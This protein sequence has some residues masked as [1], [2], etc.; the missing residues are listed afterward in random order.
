MQYEPV[1]PLL[2]IYSKKTKTLILK[3]MHP[4]DYCRISYYNQD[5]E[6]TSVS[7]HSDEWM[8]MWSLYK[9]ILLSHTKNGILPFVTTWIDIEIIMLSETIQTEED[10]QRTISF[11]CRI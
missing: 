2:G 1:I 7:I 10:K 5:M 3:D 6:A 11:L 4:Y 8:K 9:E